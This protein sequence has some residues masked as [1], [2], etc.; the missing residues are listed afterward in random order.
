MET[1]IILQTIEKIHR[2]PEALLKFQMQWWLK[3]NWNFY[4]TSTRGIDCEKPVKYTPSSYTHVRNSEDTWH[5][6]NAC[7]V[8]ARV[9]KSENVQDL[10]CLRENNEKKVWSKI[11]SKFS[12]Q[13]QF[14]G[15]SSIA[16]S[17]RLCTN[18]RLY[19]GKR[20]RQA[21]HSYCTETFR[22][23]WMNILAWDA[24]NYGVSFSHAMHTCTRAWGK[25][26][27]WI[28]AFPVLIKC[29]AIHPLYVRMH[30]MV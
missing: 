14:I 26:G 12:E 24:T 25:S 19:P 9:N 13:L 3:R 2:I 20:G 27:D 10:P 8:M 30:W 22:E 28:N 4:P 18:H 15:K 17:M 21:N 11:I 6:R 29:I 23:I 5:E 16:P 1:C 7:I